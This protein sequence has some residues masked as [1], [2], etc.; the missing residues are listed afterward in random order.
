G[1]ITALRDRTQDFGRKPKVFEPGT[2]FLGSGT[3]DFSLEFR[4][5][6]FRAGTRYGRHT[7]LD[8]RMA[9]ALAASRI[10]TANRLY[11]L[12]HSGEG[13]KVNL[14]RTQTDCQFLRLRFR[15]SRL[16]AM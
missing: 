6:S 2:A 9:G 15:M 14:R 10:G 3:Q 4:T 13:P 12:Q 8:G 16:G 1:G 11:A 5:A 7:L